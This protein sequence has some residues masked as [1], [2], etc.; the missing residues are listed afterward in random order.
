MHDHELKK[1]LEETHPV[2][3]GQEERAWNALRERLKP[4]SRR[5]W[6][7]VPTWRSA[8]VGVALLAAL[9]VGVNLGLAVRPHAPSFVSADSQ[10]PGIYA[11]AFY[12]RTAHAQVVW[13]NG[14]EP[15]SDQPTYLD[16]TTVR[17]AA[18]P[19]QP[20]GDPNSL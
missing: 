16:P 8:A 10:A 11:T 7:Y 17:H 12:S 2:R 13:L 20:A 4:S 5:A 6:L 15:A 1:L 3:P 14:L 18:K 9:A 19:A